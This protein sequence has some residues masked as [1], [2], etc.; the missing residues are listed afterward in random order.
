MES[1]ELIRAIRRDDE[2]ETWPCNDCG[3]PCPKGDQLCAACYE[4]ERLAEE[5]DLLHPEARCPPRE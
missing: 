2:I 3:K 5:W 1:T 4:K